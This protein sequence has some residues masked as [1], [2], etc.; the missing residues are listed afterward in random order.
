[1]IWVYTLQFEVS[2]PSVCVTG[3]NVAVYFHITKKAGWIARQL[4][5]PVMIY[6]HM[7]DRQEKKWLS[8]FPGHKREEKFTLPVQT[9]LCGEVTIYLEEIC[10]YDIFRRVISPDILVINISGLSGLRSLFQHKIHR[11]H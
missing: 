11:N 5:V 2:L 4:V 9:E 3:Q 8:I 7:F 1:M 6:N 10:C